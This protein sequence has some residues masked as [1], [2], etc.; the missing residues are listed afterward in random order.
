MT[1]DHQ[2]QQILDEK[3][4]AIV[5]FILKLSTKER[6]AEIK[7]QILCNKPD[8]EPYAVFRRLSRKTKG[9]ISAFNIANFQSENLF[10]ITNSNAHSILDYYGAQSSERIDKKKLTYDQ[11]LKM[12]LPKENNELRVFITQRE[13]FDVEETEYLSYD[14]E[15]ALA[16]FMQSEVQF[17]EELRE[18][19]E[20]FDTLGLDV[21]RIFRYFGA[22]ENDFLNSRNLKKFFDSNGIVVHKHEIESF[23]SRLDFD[24]DGVVSKNDFESFLSIFKAKAGRKIVQ[25]QP[26]KLGRRKSSMIDTNF[27]KS[28]SP[29]RKIVKSKVMMIPKRVLKQRNLFSNN[30]NK[31]NVCYDPNSRR[32]PLRVKITNERS[33]KSP[34]RGRK[35][36]GSRDVI[37]NKSSKMNEENFEENNRSKIEAKLALL[38]CKHEILDT[39]HLRKKKILLQL[40]RSLTKKNF[41]NSQNQITNEKPN[42]D[43]AYNEEDPTQQT[44]YSPFKTGM[45]LKLEKRIEKMEYESQ[46]RKTP[47]KSEWRPNFEEKSKNKLDP[48]NTTMITEIKCNISSINPYKYDSN[49]EEELQQES[50]QK[51]SYYNKLYSQ[52]ST[53]AGSNSHQYANSKTSIPSVP[54]NY[55]YCSISNMMLQALKEIKFLDTLKRR[56]FYTKD[57]CFETFC[58]IFNFDRFREETLDFQAFSLLL[59]EMRINERYKDDYELVFKKISRLKDSYSSP[60]LIFE[61]LLPAEESFQDYLVSEGD[62]DKESIIILVRE[63]IEQ[64]FKVEEEF[65]GV[66]DFI[67]LH[68]VNVMDFFDAVDKEKL[69]EIVT[70]NLKSFFSEYNSGQYDPTTEE[71]ELF[72][73]YL[74]N[75]GKT[76]LGY[77]D[78]YLKLM[79]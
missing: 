71:V 33:L 27:L 35:R 10:K 9:G 70:S 40:S 19:K 73:C 16:N 43:F 20:K 57:F 59:N 28:M 51:Q 15:L 34:H 74:G 30:Q 39:S 46:Y 72:I 58:S 32:T 37:L 3:K 75:D 60:A 76:R 52:L 65:I 68:G 50:L 21:S 24:N 62:F 7:R 61:L 8:F 49:L 18:E 11:F 66:K 5:N 78:L 31:E 67:S 26:K 36:F 17:F 2:S 6:F 77:R 13:C 54:S 45:E 25:N 12:V 22:D 38:D 47:P 64:V 56:L 69:G 48:R 53:A 41:R 29:S 63:I 14:T 42:M 23:I 55:Q 1:K 79:R 44:M 4:E